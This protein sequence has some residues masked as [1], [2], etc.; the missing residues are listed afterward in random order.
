M[1]SLAFT[2][3][4][5]LKIYGGEPDGQ[6]FAVRLQVRY[7]PADVANGLI[8]GEEDLDVRVVIGGVSRLEN[9]GYLSQTSGGERAGLIVEIRNGVIRSQLARG[10][11]IES[12][13]HAERR[14]IVQVL[15]DTR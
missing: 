5:C 2:S 10:W 1:Q 6:I 4:A 11:P 14:V 3:A 7:S 12:K 8:T 9:R 15:A 13:V